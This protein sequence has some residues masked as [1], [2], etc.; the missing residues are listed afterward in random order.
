MDG[1]R[2][3]SLLADPDQWARCAH[4]GVALSATGGIQLT[5]HD[6][7]PPPYAG[8]AASPLPSA[9]PASPASPGRRAAAGG[10]AFDRRGFAYRSRTA[11]GRIDT[12]RPG[13]GEPSQAPGGPYDEPRA[14]A[15]DA[16]RLLYVAT[17]RAVVV[18][19]IDA[20]ERLTELPVTAR[21]LTV[22]DEVVYALTAGGIVLIQ[23]CRGPRPG[24]G[25][26]RPRCHGPLEAYR[27]A[28]CADGRL[29]VLW[30]SPDDT[31]AVVA[32]P[33]GAVAV[34]A[35]G[36]TDLTVTSGGTLV[37]ARE[38]GRSFLRFDEH[39]GA[40]LELEPVRA[41]GYDGGAIA[42]H[43]SGPSQVCHGADSGGASRVIGFTTAEGVAD[44]GGIA[45]RYRTS[46]GTVTYRLDSGAYRTRWGR[47]FLEACLPRGTAVRLR[48][49]TGDDD[50]PPPDALRWTPADRNGRVIRR[51]DLT[52][53]L[54]SALALDTTAPA[55]APFKRPTGPETPWTQ[56]ACDD[57]FET[58]ELPVSAPP[59]R[60]LW[61]AL[62]LTG[63]EAATP[64]IRA[65]RVERPGHGLLRR[66][67]RS[68]SRDEGDARFLHRWLTP[69]E[70]LLHELDERAARRDLLLDPETTPQ[71][72]LEWLA[73]FAGLALDRR[74]PEHARRTLVGRAYR[75][76][77][78]R[79]TLASLRELLGIYLGWEPVI[80]ERWR[81]RGVP[82]GLLGRPP[83]GAT[84]ADAVVGRMRIGSPPGHDAAAHRFSVL[85]PADL[86][87]EQADVLRSI[88]EL[89][90]PA[91]TSYDICEIGLGMRVGRRLHAGL[92]SIVGPGAGW[93]PIVLGRA[94]LGTDGVLGVP[95][96]RVLR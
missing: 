29:L 32:T 13:G 46:G 57:L 8:D 85:V 65:V 34:A 96:P 64:R 78:G 47:A 70:G 59:G 5:W 51:P 94:R 39:D 56:I 80:V 24:P 40:W 48:F 74:W 89:H 52:P 79:G 41:T 19:A 9:S 63:T 42:N 62:D 68:W 21:D 26:I 61:L 14:L 76:F 33:E 31:H 50:D 49:V 60:Y 66:L 71:E 54:P 27:L 75:L 7:P 90:K 35:P 11:D 55:A 43:P 58:Y 20:G 69:P 83:E 12:Y 86:T 2:G 17:R 1:D 23:G 3:V 91:H 36:A 95:S 25:L 30:V 84:G 15:I 93:R 45:G 73:G 67:P 10:L 22:H 37:V 38:P 28:V 44:T 92:T 4:E 53:P 81:I 18:T 16:A 72:A 6:D 88:L 77:R 82:G 87:T